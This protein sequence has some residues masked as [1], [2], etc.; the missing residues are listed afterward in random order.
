[1]KPI[2][3]EKMPLTI[4]TRFVL[5]LRYFLAYTIFAP[6][7]I[8]C[9]Y[10]PVASRKFYSKAIVHQPFDVI[11][12]PGVP[13]DGKKWSISMK[14]RVYWSV[15]LYQKGM[16]RNIIYSGGAVYSPY[17]ESI[18]MA[19]YAEV[20]GVEKEN[21]Y[22]ETESEFSCENLY[23]SWLL[24]KKLGFD[25]VAVATDPFQTRKLKRFKNK[26]N[27]PVIFIPVVFDT[28]AAI[29]QIDP[30]IDTS[31][32][33]FTEFV[34]FTKRHSFRDIGRCTKGGRIMKIMHEK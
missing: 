8:A 33:Y 23:Y 29:Q 24:A 11:I 13:F 21:I 7:L 10:F 4:K 26:F 6:W 22:T 9:S 2:L 3:M 16:A 34:P 18:I 14:A 15:Y 31:G 27:L 30:V 1:M 17:Y 19:R 25:K 28:L 32:A 5:V 20:L 12:V